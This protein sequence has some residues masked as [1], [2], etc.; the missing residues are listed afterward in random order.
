MP[1][2]NPSIYSIHIHKLVEHCALSVFGVTMPAL[3]SRSRTA[4]VAVARQTAMYLAHVAFGLSFTDVGE[5]FSRD[6]TTVA[7]ACRLI[8]ELRDDPVMDKALTVIETTLTTLP[9][10]DEDRSVGDNIF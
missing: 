8:E 7:H 6:R 10:P 4:A 5:L 3:R 9:R 1:S 2:S